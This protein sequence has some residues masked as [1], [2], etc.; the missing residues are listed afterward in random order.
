MT[1]ETIETKIDTIDKKLDYIIE[2][3]REEDLHYPYH[4]TYMNTNYSDNN[5]DQ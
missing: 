1:W 4:G 3:I 2:L 5:E